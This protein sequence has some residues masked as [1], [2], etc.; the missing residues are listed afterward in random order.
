[1]ANYATLQAAIDAGTSNMTVLRN[2]S[3]N[4]DG[5]TTYA[6]EIDWFKFNSV[7]V[8]NLYSSGNSWLGFGA[9][10]EQLKVNRRDCAVWYEYKEIGIIGA[11][12]FF[13]FRWVGYSYNGQTGSSYSQ[14]FDVFLFDNSQIFLRFYQVPSSNRDGQN[15]L[16]C[17]SQTLNYTIS[18][19][20]CEFT[21]T[22]SDPVNGTGW[23][24]GS[25]RPKTNPYKSAG[26]TVFTVNNY[27]VGGEDAL[28]W[29]GDTPTG[30][31]IKLYT[32]V[33]EGTY[34]EI[35]TSGGRIQGL[36]SSGTCTLYIKAELATTD[37]SKTPKLTSITLKANDDK[38]VIVLSLAIPN[39]SPAIGP[40]TV[41]Y[42]GLGDLQGIGGPS[43]AFAGDFTPQGLT[44]KGGQND[45]E[46]IET[47]ITASANLTE[48][49]YNNSQESEHVEISSIIATATLTNIHDL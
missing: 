4:D 5:T 38:K 40:V 9:S 49:V 28:H 46:H 24:V 35:A 1:M 34:T 2:N 21:F 25:E 33:N 36:P 15:Q 48:I 10:A 20:P 45:E 39:L 32:K 41:S 18:A 44:W 37:G 26:S 47:H 29:T 23:S 31:S 12:R 17:G 43:E 22:P 27:V 19:T 7:L 42:D 13:K 16:I 30:T 3:K 8:S 14:A 11:R 6:T